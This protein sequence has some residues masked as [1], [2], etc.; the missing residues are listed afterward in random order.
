MCGGP[1]VEVQQA[2]ESVRNTWVSYMSA[3]KP[4]LITG[5]AIESATSLLAPWG[6]ELAAMDVAK[7]YGQ[8]GFALSPSMFPTVVPSFSPAKPSGAGGETKPGAVN[9][10]KGGT[11]D[12]SPKGTF[13]LLPGKLGLPVT[14]NKMQYLC[15]HAA[16]AVIYWVKDQIRKIP[17]VGRVIDLPGI[18]SVVNFGVDFGGDTVMTLLCNESGGVGVPLPS[19]DI[20]WKGFFVGPKT[21]WSQAQNGNDWMQ[22]WGFAADAKYSERSEQKVAVAGHQTNLLLGKDPEI[23]TFNAQA[24]FYYDCQ[25]AWSTCNENDTPAFS[26]RWRVR[27]RRFRTPNVEGMLLGLGSEV[28]FSNGIVDALRGKVKNTKPFQKI[29]EKIASFNGL[30]KWLGDKA[31]DSFARDQNAASSPNKIA[32][33]IR[34]KLGPGG[35]S[36]DEESFH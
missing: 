24:E 23:P 1:A 28:I 35:S 31:V 25:S 19:L 30:K 21:M 29:E 17:V 15:K 7:R 9:L 34:T 36:A 22:V 12:V 3:A 6:G 26:M 10:E 27:L 33:K 4:V 14:E 16:G 8:T 11:T 18:K 13:G 32:T 5:A 20:F 2:A